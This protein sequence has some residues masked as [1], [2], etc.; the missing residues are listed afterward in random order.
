MIPALPSFA[1]IY[2]LTQG[3]PLGSTTTVNYLIY[4]TAFQYNEF[5]SSAAMAFVLF[6]FI[7]GAS[8]ITM[9]GMLGR[10]R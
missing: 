3:G 2:V 7:G 4:T 5:G 6:A 10:S 9:R 1:E 8:I